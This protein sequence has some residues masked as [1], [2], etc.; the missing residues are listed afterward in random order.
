MTYQHWLNTYIEWDGGL[1][2][3]KDC[4]SD[5]VKN[6]LYPFITEKGYTFNVS[7]KFLQSA[8][9]TGLYE[10]A[11]EPHIKSEWNYAGP[12]GNTEWDLEGL[13]HF[14]HVVNDE[15]WARFWSTWGNWSDVSLDYFR[16]IDRRYDIQHYIRN[17]I[18][19]DASGQTEVL[20]EMLND[21][22]E[23]DVSMRKSGIDTYI[24]DYGDGT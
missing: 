8:C 3:R 5:F 9:A 18:D 13:A 17:C 16:G 11:N 2:L 21:A 24:Q 7:T 12:G 20:D 19:I 1:R 23:Y 4:I 10:N 14:Y 6:G 22:E 15:A